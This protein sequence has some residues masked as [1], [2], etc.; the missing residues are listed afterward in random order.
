MKS[1]FIQSRLNQLATALL[2]VAM[3]LASQSVQLVQAD[4]NS[5]NT[6]APTPTSTS[7]APPLTSTV[8][9][10]PTL[11]PTFTP[12]N[13]PAASN[14]PTFVPTNTPAPTPTSTPSGL[15][16]TVT[17]PNGGEVMTAG[18][19][20]TITW[21]SSPYINSIWIGYSGCT[22]CLN[23]I[24]TGS[25]NTGSYNWTV[26]V[27]N[28]TNTQFKIEITGYE[29]GVGS[30]T[31][32]S[33][34]PFTVLQLP[35]PTFTP[36]KTATIRP[37]ITPTFIPTNTPTASATPIFTSTNTNT[38]TNTS[39]AT[40]TPTA[41]ATWTPTLTVTPWRA[42]GIRYVRP[43]ASGAGS[44]NS[45]ADACTLQTALTGSVNG[46]EIWAAAGIYTPTT[47]TD[48][49]ATFQLVSGVSVYGGFAGTE[50]VRSQRNPTTNVTILSG[51]IDNNDS[52][53]PDNNQPR[54]R[55]R[56]YYQ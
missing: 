25:P 27:G 23:W 35:T 19:I 30:V 34:A 16:L 38:A 41:T 6:P 9:S 36:M 55:H 11:A 18:N 15:W 47:G 40:N 8:L 14:T 22:G 2:I 1:P 28:T 53:N 4:T 37:T 29:T 24:T 48:R 33:D 32:D 39:T 17:A 7:S 21:Q 42:A 20:Y 12:T 52:Q 50:T 43:V 56:Q 54:Y 26:N 49:N 3:S 10:T 5:T 13:I 31:D 45:W 46:D 44:C 51:D